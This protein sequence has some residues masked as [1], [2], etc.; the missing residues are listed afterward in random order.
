MIRRVCSNEPDQRLAL[1]ARATFLLS[2]LL[3]IG[4]TIACTPN[5]SSSANYEHA[6]ATFVHGDLVASQREAEEGYRQFRR[7]SP[8]LAW[9]Y[10]VLEAESLLW[11]GRYQEVLTLLDSSAADPAPRDLKVSVLALQAVALGRRLDLTAADQKLQE[12]ERLCTDPKVEGCG[13]AFQARGLLALGQ[14]QF[15]QAQ[16]SFRSSLTIAKTKRDTF[17]E[18]TSLLNLGGALV[19]EGLFDEAIDSSN[20]AYKA[21]LVLGAD[22]IALAAQENLAWSY[23]RLGDSPRA[24]DVL[25]EAEK[26]SQQL[27]D[28]FDQENALTNIGYVYM[29]ERRVDLAEQAFSQALT[30]A[31][32]EGRKEHIFNTL[33]VL[34]RLS[35]Q[36]GD[37]LTASKYAQQAIDIA[38]AGGNH[39]DELYPTLVQGQIESQSADPSEAQKIFEA[40]IRDEIC[41]VFLKWDA[42][43]SLALL[44]EREKQTDGADREYRAA[45]ATFEGARSTV[46][47]GDFQLSFLTNGELIYDDYVHF[48]VTQGRTDEALRWADYSRART[49]SE[50]LGLLSKRRRTPYPRDL[51]L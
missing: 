36:T 1:Q 40:V 12:A 15:A 14:N 30:L 39:L 21:A 22:D 51:Q 16:I 27:G 29:D 26:R 10:K 18:T 44:Y 31:Q 49:L 42:Q 11:S 8:E 7:S 43:H 4:L 20:A 17:L 23:Y 50:G 6:R 46:R 32:N 37:I 45:L 13:E 28:T 47:H 19:K 25:L 2:L 48:L 5:Q 35:L 24:L 34:A 38:R 41:P 33:R 9:K 3:V